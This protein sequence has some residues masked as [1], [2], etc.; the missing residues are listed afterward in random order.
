MMERRLEVH[1]NKT[2]RLDNVLI[3]QV[4][5]TMDLSSESEEI[6]K[7]DFLEL[8]VT[9][10]EN[11]IRSK[12]ANT[13][14]P[15]IQYSGLEFSN[16]EMG[17]SMSFMVQA[18]KYINNVDQGFTMESVIKV[19]NCMYIR[20]EGREEDLQIAYKKIEVEAYE[21][22]IALKGSSY[23]I[24]VDADDEGNIVADIFMEKE[25]E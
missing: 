6:P 19:S 18:D 7:E 21:N 14:G 25:N 9:Q 4:I 23:T 12:G 15:L 1:K 22:D 16:E 24:F 17:L 10:M 13:V 3:K 5:N 20:F 2:L 8:A 11:Q